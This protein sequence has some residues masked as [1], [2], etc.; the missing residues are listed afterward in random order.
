MHFD[1]AKADLNVR[2]ISYIPDSQRRPGARPRLEESLVSK[3]LPILRGCIGLLVLCMASLAA[4]AQSGASVA[5]SEMFDAGVAAS[6]TDAN[7]LTYVASA[8][9]IFTLSATGSVLSTRTLQG[10]TFRALAVDAAGAIY[11]TGDYACPAGCVPPP[12]VFTNGTPPTTPGGVAVAKITSDGTLAYLDVFVASNPTNT[13]D[14][15]ATGIA[16]DSTGTAVIVGSTP[17]GWPTTS[18]SLHPN[19]TFGTRLGFVTRIATNGQTFVYS[20]YLDGASGGSAP[21]AVASDSAGTA[22]VTGSTSALDFPTTP[23]AFSTTNLAGNAGFVS[24]INPTGTQFFYSTFIPNGAGGAIAIDA[25]GN[26]YIAGAT[27][28][29]LAVTAGVVTATFAPDAT[30]A[31][32]NFAAKVNAAGSALTYATY[33]AIAQ[34]SPKNGAGTAVYLSTR[35][36]ITVDVAGDAF[37][38]GTTNHP[39][40][41]TVNA[42]QSALGDGAFFGG[43]FAGD[44]YIVELN[45]TATQYLMSTYLGGRDG[46]SVTGLGLGPD[47]AIYA[48]GSTFINQFPLLLQAGGS[49]AGIS[50]FLTKIAPGAGTAVPVLFPADRPPVGTAENVGELDFGQAQSGASVTKRFRLGNYGGSTLTVGAIAATGDFK[51]QSACPATLSAGAAC[52]ITVTFTPANSGARSGTLTVATNSSAGLT[53]NRL[54]ATAIGPA[55]QLSTRTLSFGVQAVGATSAPQTVTVTNSGSTSLT[56]TSI[57]A[58]GDYA[59]SGNTCTAPV[60]PQASCQ[61]SITFT[62][63][64]TGERD[65]TLTITDNAFDSP[66]TVSLIG[67]IAADFALAVPTGAPTSITTTAGNSAT[68]TLQL[69]PSG[70][71]QGV[72]SIACSGAPTGAACTP[73]TNSITLV[74]AGAPTFTVAVTTTAHNTSSIQPVVASGFVPRAPWLLLPLALALLWFGARRRRFLLAV[75]PMFLLALVA[76]VGLGFTLGCGGSKKKTDLTTT[77]TPAGTYTLTITAASG[78]IS[79]TQTLTLGVQ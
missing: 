39:G 27:S 21:A 13:N 63:T 49:S 77:G 43:A 55:V 35:V 65:G 26:A 11:A 17:C 8:N 22:Y 53:T 33:L 71:F 20:T 30:G 56:F 58:S 78:S 47:G 74:G 42:V 19:C 67:G 23:G 44:G 25:A 76:I 15:V 75:K 24:K 66:Q 2:L 1:S 41:P 7:G 60:A 64:A 70:G 37:I 79:H 59:V 5:N 34:Q 29:S 32:A 50:G 40:G 51:A 31:A 61:V 3:Y 45:P 6:V 57:T 54:T 28:G 72:V 9:R 18:G 38:A 48:G 46:D 52:D 4:T 62:P 68:F 14:A 36:A 73:S 69:T 12:F 10:L 16:V